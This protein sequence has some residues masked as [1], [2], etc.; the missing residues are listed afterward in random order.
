MIVYDYIF[1]LLWRDIK[2]ATKNGIGKVGGFTILFSIFYS[3]GTHV[4]TGAH[5]YNIIL[6]IQ[7]FP[8]IFRSH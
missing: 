2:K 4:F 5:V 8:F 1:Y 7:W 3:A 6:Q